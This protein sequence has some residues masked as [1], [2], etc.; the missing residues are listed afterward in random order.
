MR[1]VLLVLL[2]SGLVI[3]LVAPPVDAW[4]PRP[5]YVVWGPGAILAAPFVIAGALIAAPFIIAHSVVT[6]VTAPALAPAPAV[7]GPQ[8]MAAAPSMAPGAYWYYCPAAR[9]YYPY[10]SQCPGGWMQVVP[11]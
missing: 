4:G 3:G 2:V 1:N 6:S 11:R 10:V 7:I 5:H 8:P 9:A